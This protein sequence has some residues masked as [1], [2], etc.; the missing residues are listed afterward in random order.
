[1][2]KLKTF[3]GPPKKEEESID[4]DGNIQLNEISGNIKNQF[5]NK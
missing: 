1:M 4:I 5:F 3:K 2:K